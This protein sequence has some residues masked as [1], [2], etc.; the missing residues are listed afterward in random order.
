MVHA[1][2]SAVFL[3]L[4]LGG[5]LPTA[6]GQENAPRSPEQ[7]LGYPVGT[8]FTPHARLEG[9]LRHLAEASP[10]VAL[11]VYGTSWEGR[12]LMLLAISSEEN[13]SD[14]EAIRERLAT[15][16][17][18]RRLAPDADLEALIEATPVAVWL[19]YNV[20]GNETS[21]SEAALQVV[22]RLA[23]ARDEESLHWLEEAVV[24]VDPCLNPDGRD[25]YV[26]WFNGVVGRR[27]DPDVRSFEHDEPWPGGRY[28]HYLFDLNRDWAFATQKETR[29]RLPLFLAWN[30][31]VHVDFHEMGYGSTYFFFP[32]E[33]PINTNLP[34]HVLE[35]GRRFGEGNARAFD[36]HGWAYYSGEDFDLFYPGYGDSWPSFTGAIGMTYEQAGHGRAGAAVERDDGT[37]LTLADRVDHHVVASFSTIRTAVEGR[38]ELLRG[39]QEFRRSAIEEGR[40]GPVRAFVLPPGGDPARLQALVDL[41]Q[42]QGIEVRRSREAFTLR[43]VKDALGGRVLDRTFPAGTC[44]V[45]LDQPLKRLA[46]TLLE[47]RTE[48]KELQFYDVAAWSLP[49]AHGVDVYE[50]PVAVEADWVPASAPV[51]PAGGVAPG[52]AQVAFLLRYDHQG[53][54]EALADLLRE[55]IRV[56]SA[57]EP[58]AFG[59]REYDRGTLVIRANENSPDLR[60]RLAAIGATRRVTFQPAST[61]LTD[62]GVDLGSSSVVPVVPP[63][64][65]LVG[66]EGISATS[67]GAARFLLDQVL[68]VRHSVMA[69]EVLQRIDL[70]D[71][72]AV[73]IPEGRVAREVA[74]ALG[75]YVDE[76]GVVVALGRAA[77]ALAGEQGPARI[78][79][80]DAPEETE[81]EGDERPRWIEERVEVARR[82]QAPGSIFAIELDPA[83]PL[84]FGY[85]AAIAAFKAGTRSFD[86]EGPGTHVGLFRDA[87]ELSGYVNPATA[88]GL[89]GRSYLSVDGRGRGA[90]VLFADDPNFRGAWR[91][92]TRLFVN[93][94][95]L[96]PQPRR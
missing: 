89:E 23:T 41:L 11:Q 86:P 47:P 6:H 50:S 61:G 37:L 76:G 20:H 65:L 31:H 10:R 18:P 39:Y 38:V 25:R 43:Q 87:A 34:E 55:G 1:L 27:P 44:I 84:S 19:S 71:F 62:R 4:T 14:L 88:V 52:N 85:E 63:R 66:G 73:V 45:A 95:L 92:L 57:R 17:D 68:D 94:A 96:L 5:T 7:W 12:P 60:E 9:Y 30:P 51:A 56:R 3:L 82:R 13:I 79:H 29:A 59:D 81:A 77:F 93:A 22:Y 40:E 64:L 74:D 90:M 2:L 72:T 49:L 75:E 28:N 58:F 26:N 91:G 35:W 69:P 24:L 21:S 32:A 83:H 54:I 8:R 80:G 42:L 33:K 46:K 48:I 67:F 78:R 36:E 53:A 16:A 15:L 70:G